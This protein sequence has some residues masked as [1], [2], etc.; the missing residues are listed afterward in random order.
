VVVW[1]VSVL[2]VSES[3]SVSMS[4]SV[5]ERSAYEYPALIHLALPSTTL[6]TH[7]HLSTGVQSSELGQVIHILSNNNPRVGGLVMPCDL[8][9][10]VLRAH[11]GVDRRVGSRG[12]DARVDLNTHCS[13]VFIA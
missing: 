11:A 2:L 12:E 6:Y 10:R 4:V 3:M 7:T 5:I 8:S 13:V 1:C 9:A